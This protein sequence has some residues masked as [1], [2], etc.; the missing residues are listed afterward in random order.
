MVWALIPADSLRGAQKYYIFSKGTYH[1]GRKDCDI[2]VQT[3]TSISRNHAE[4]VIDN[5]ISLDPYK[6]GSVGSPSG[7]RVIDKSKYGTFISKESGSKVRLVKN[8]DA[9]LDN[10]DFVTFGTSNATFQLCYVPVSIFIHGSKDALLDSSLQDIGSSIGARSSLK[11][12]HECTHVLVEESTSITIDLIEAVLAKRP[13]VLG[14]WFKVLVEKTI[15]TEFP[16]CIPYTP[17]LIF[18]G[19][20]IRIVEPN[21]RDRCLEGFTFVLGSLS[22]YQ[23]GEKFRSLLEVVG[24]KFITAEDFCSD[25]QTSADGESNFVLVVPQESPNELN[26]F[27]ELSSLSRITDLKLAIAILSGSLDSSNLEQPSIVVSS[28]HSTDETIVADSDVEIDTATSNTVTTAAKFQDAMKHENEDQGSKK[29]EDTENATEHQEKRKSIDNL[30]SS[31]NNTTIPCPRDDGVAPMKK[32]DKGAEPL[33]DR[34]ENS[35]IIYTQNLIV[36]DITIPVPARSTTKNTANFKRFRKANMVSG[37]SFRDLI[38]FSK[39]P[40][41]E[42]DY[43]RTEVEHMQEEKKRKQLEAIAEDLFNNEKGRKRP[44]AGASIKSFLT[45]R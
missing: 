26:R 7:V 28:S 9:E 3:D 23:F 22:K 5:M 41:K 39:D 14:D 36:K 2:I 42:S 4:I 20:K 31:S 34:H 24:A 21:V 19:I 35:D 16:S 37:N 33:A 30:D 43:G 13:I 38:P 44:A 27:R 17:T 1:V 25:S 45:R 32:L 10:G 8:K 12:N 6:A 11:W 29:P 40:Y 15:R 18:K